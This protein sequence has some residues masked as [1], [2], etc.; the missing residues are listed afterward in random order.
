MK[1][2]PILFSSEMVRAILEGRKTMTRR[3]VKPGAGMQSEWLTHDLI[4]KVPHGKV[5]NGGWQMH[6]PLAGQRHIVL[7]KTIDEPEDSP[8]GWVRC[9]YG[10]TGDTLWVRENLQLLE[11][12]DDEWGW[13]YQADEKEIVG[14][15]DSEKTC[16][17]FGDPLQVIP[18]IFMPRW[19]SRI[20]LLIKGVRVERLQDI[21]ERDAEAEGVTQR[22][23]SGTAGYDDHGIGSY[24]VAFRNLWDSI[25]GKKAPWSSN[26]WVWII[27]FEV[28]K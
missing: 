26:P 27:E 4:Q 16:L 20:N 19:A 9:P 18:S 28:V 13:C 3:L 25:N 24:C 17:P 23:Y 2:R 7:G 1:E 11:N 10:K 21:S 12:D 15:P 22:V 6:H 14:T 8:L 5:T